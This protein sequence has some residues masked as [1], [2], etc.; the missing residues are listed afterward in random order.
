M[1]ASALTPELQSRIST[2]LADFSWRLHNTTACE[3]S[4]LHAECTPSWKGQ[5][6]EWRRL[7]EHGERVRVWMHALDTGTFLPDGR[8]P[9][10]SRTMFRTNAD[11]M[12]KPLTL[13]QPLAAFTPEYKCG[14]R[15]RVAAAGDGSTRRKFAAGAVAQDD[16]HKD[17]CSRSVVS[18]CNVLSVG[19]N[20]QDGF[21][22]ALSAAAKCR[23]YVV[24]P[25]L[26]SETSAPV[27]AFASRL[28]AYG[29]WLNASV[30]LGAKGTHMRLGSGQSGARRPKVPLWH[31]LKAA[32][33]LG[34]DGPR[35]H[36]SVMK[37]DC[38]GCEFEAL[39]HPTWGAWRLCASGYLTIDELVVEVHAA[40]QRA[41]HADLH[42][43]FAGALDC[44]LMLHH[45]EVN[46]QGCKRGNCAEF[47]WVN[48]RHAARA[49]AADGSTREAKRE[50]I[51]KR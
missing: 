49:A 45:K 1:K 43:L 14:S 38:E 21:E 20:F 16:G 26:G 51:E 33:W 34:C 42:E 46:W 17:L 27:V 25:T 24:D 6:R 3:S 11:M 9:M 35:C 36:L 4:A 39:T 48:V 47:S 37:L 30:G 22:R 29:A 15:W 50:E 40:K 19:S 12:G 44:G 18:P 32:P 28:R 13:Y 7:V 8:K 23:T 2:H 31:L 5:E 41:T 10:L